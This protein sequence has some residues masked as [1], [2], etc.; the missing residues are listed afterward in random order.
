MRS[1]ATGPSSVCC[2]GTC[3]YDN[4]ESLD[5]TVVDAT[6]AYDCLRSVPFL[7]AV[8]SRLIQYINDTIQFHS[9]VAYL[10]RPPSGYQ[11]PAVD[12]ASELGQIQRDIDNSVFGNEYDFEL[13]IYTLLHAAHDDHL[14]L[15][16]GILSAFS[17]GSPID[18][19]ALSLDGISLPKVYIASKIL[20]PERSQR[21]QKKAKA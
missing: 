8:A 18:I 4:A 21:R 17:Y 7:P 11:Q 12:L 16:G 2:G 20:R 13:A 9:T 15:Q 3:I 1:Y 10:A 19:V 6:Q 14:S 5:F